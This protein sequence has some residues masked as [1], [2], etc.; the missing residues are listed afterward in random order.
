MVSSQLPTNDTGK[1][2]GAWTFCFNANKEV[3]F[4]QLRIRGLDIPG[5]KVEPDEVHLY[6]S[7][8]DLG[9]ATA[10]RET[11]EETKIQPINLKLIGWRHF[12]S[13]GPQ[14]AQSKFPFPDCY[15]LYYYAEVGEI[16]EFTAEPQ[17]NGAIARVFL[18]EAQAVSE[19]KIQMHKYL[20]ARA[21]SMAKNS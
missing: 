5:G 15:F 21:L 18:P 13:D 14:P 16:H 8:N 2:G 11:I 4:T 12:H 20:F 19:P 9:V 17:P 7:V 6:S 1:I 3:L 10:T